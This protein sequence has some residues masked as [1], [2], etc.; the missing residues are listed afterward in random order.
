M[1]LGKDCKSA[2]MRNL[3]EEIR[4]SQRVKLLLSQRN[5]K[6][7]IPFHPYRKWFG[8]H[9][10]LSSLAE[11]EHPPND[12]E[13]IPL[14]EQICEWLFSKQHLDSIRCI[15]DRFRRCASQEGNAIH[16]MLKLGLADSRVDEI[17][18]RLLS[19]QWPDGGWNCDKRPKAVNSSFVET[20]IP[21]RAL[22]LHA[23]ITGNKKSKAAAQ[24]AA[25]VF[26][27]RRLYK[28]RSDGHIIKDAFIELHYP[29]YYHY[30]ILFG[31][32][33]MAESGFINDDRCNDALDLLESK[34]L[35]AGGFP[36]QKN[37]YRRS[38][39]QISGRSLVDWGKTGK[40]FMNEFVTMD[41]M[42]VLKAAGRL[43][44]E[45]LVGD[46]KSLLSSGT[47]DSGLNH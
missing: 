43:N 28:R 9:W 30:D 25:E 3:R 32:K 13:L 14:K 7:K 16:A 27:K 46:G 2:Q 19:F 15:Q 40:S 8:A 38:R 45:D 36:V 47:G 1:L 23:K 5:E 33:V 37:Y 11:I 12:N 34:Q 24:R 20:L 18:E 44:L 22:S 35:L 31:L 39:Q 21:L 10:V 42:Y 6:G 26:L 17:I 41:A 4:N 29:C